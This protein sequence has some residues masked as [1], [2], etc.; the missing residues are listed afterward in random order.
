MVVYPVGPWLVLSV[1]GWL[2]KDPHHG[3]TWIQRHQWQA[4]LECLGPNFI[5]LLS[6]QICLAWNFSLDKNRI[7]NQISIGCILLDTGIIESVLTLC[8]YSAVVCWKS[9][10]S[11]E[12]LVGNPVF[13]IKKNFH[14]KHSIFVRLAA[15]W[16]W[17][18]LAWIHGHHGYIM[19]Q[20]CVHA[21]QVQCI[22]GYHRKRNT[23][24]SPMKRIET[25]QAECGPLVIARL[26]KLLYIVWLRNPGQQL[27]GVNWQHNRAKVWYSH[28]YYRVALHFGTQYT[29]WCLYRLGLG[30]I[31]QLLRPAI[32]P[33]HFYSLNEKQRRDK[34]IIMVEN[35]P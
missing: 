18:L 17:A 22:P 1:Y 10:I 12:I 6:T 14:A 8:W 19:G 27:S 33:P 21:Q 13:I 3:H 26:N 34:R 11:C 15:L 2:P 29:S 7:T 9:K 32:A 23:L 16:N 25:R 30:K 31:L 24:Y 20:P 35:S 28:I 5:E 4:W